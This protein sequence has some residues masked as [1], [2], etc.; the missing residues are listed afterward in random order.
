M[1]YDQARIGDNPTHCAD[2]EWAYEDGENFKKL[3]MEVLGMPEDRI[4]VYKDVTKNEMKDICYTIKEKAKKNKELGNLA[5]NLGHI[6]YCS[7]HGVETNVLNLVLN[8]SLLCDRY[9]EI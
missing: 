5:L 6:F 1:K 8:D 4:K 7:T 2:L 9:F 3:L